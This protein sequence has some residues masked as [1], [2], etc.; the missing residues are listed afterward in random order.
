MLRSEPAWRRLAR[1]AALYDEI[2]RSDLRKL[3][4]ALSAEQLHPILFKGAA[5]A[6]S[7]YAEAWL[8]PRGDADLLLS[9]A[10]ARRAGVILEAR[11]F[12]RSG[13]P[14][15]STR[16]PGALPGACWRYRAGL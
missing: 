10:E 6:S 1:E 15:G 14:R 12:L 7:H 9:E 4:R 3:M 13:A 2:Q 8:R 11:G 5:L 16:H